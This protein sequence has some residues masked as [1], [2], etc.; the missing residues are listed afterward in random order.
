LN[1]G[2][3]FSLPCVH[4]HRKTVGYQV[5]VVVLLSIV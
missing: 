4:R 1:V 2:L 5:F 3:T